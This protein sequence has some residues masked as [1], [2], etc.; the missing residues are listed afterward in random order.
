MVCQDSAEGES[1]SVFFFGEGRW[2]MGERRG[3][4]EGVK[5]E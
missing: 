2:M 3:G 5:K 1:K 4:G